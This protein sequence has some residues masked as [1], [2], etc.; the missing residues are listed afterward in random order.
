[1]LTGLRKGHCL[2]HLLL[3]LFHQI[4]LGILLLTWFYYL[5]WPLI[6]CPLLHPLG[7]VNS[8]SVLPA[9]WVDSSSGEEG[10]SFLTCTGLKALGTQSQPESQGITLLKK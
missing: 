9:A 5:T 1:M 3:T 8:A 6:F 7:E 2:F 10:L 4:T